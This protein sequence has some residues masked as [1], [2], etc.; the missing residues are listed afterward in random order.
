MKRGIILLLLVLALIVSAIIIIFSQNPLSETELLQRAEDY[1]FLTES[2]RSVGY[3]D[4]VALKEN[5]TIEE[6]LRSLWLRER[7]SDYARKH[8]ELLVLLGNFD[9][10]AEGLK[11]IVSYGDTPK[12]PYYQGWPRN[13]RYVTS[14]SAARF[15]A[16]EVLWLMLLLPDAD[17]PEEHHGLRDVLVECGEC[18]LMRGLLSNATEESI[19]FYY[20]KTT[21]GLLG[22]V[23][24]GYP[25]YFSDEMKTSFQSANDDIQN[26]FLQVIDA[27]S[28]RDIYYS[29]SPARVF[30]FDEAEE[31]MKEFPP[32][33]SWD[34]GYI[35]VADFDHGKHDI[36]ASVK[37]AYKYAEECDALVPV[38]NPADARFVVCEKYTNGVYYATYTGSR[39]FD[40]YLL[41]L[42]IRI[43]DLLTGEEIFRESVLSHPPPEEISWSSYYGIGGLKI[44]DEEY[45]HN[46]FDYGRY[47]AVMVAYMD[48]TEIDHGDLDNDRYAPV[49]TAH[50]K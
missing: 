48:G 12:N 39:D 9:F 23:N 11:N 6:N 16:K 27:G 5:N 24:P 42:N 26:R 28:F 19:W 41:N 13:S 8:A 37:G 22:K 30:S 14:S 40:A 46:D 47:A 36:N 29:H 50:M 25:R 15:K 32:T 17:F 1:A 44:V 20:E 31:L 38:I 49:L 10:I 21:P 18:V 45:Y 4:A 34:G 43:V 35:R 33:G 3:I 7:T 2:L